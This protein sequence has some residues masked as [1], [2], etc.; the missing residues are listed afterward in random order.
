MALAF[1]KTYNFYHWT[2]SYEG[3]QENHARETLYNLK[4][5]FVSAG[6]IVE[7]SHDGGGTNLGNNDQVDHW[8]STSVFSRPGGND[9]WIV[10]KAPALFG[11]LQICIVCNYSSGTSWLHRWDVFVSPSAGFGSANGG[12]DGTATA[13]PTAT[14]QTSD[15]SDDYY[16]VPAHTEWHIAA[17]TDDSQFIILNR[18]GAVTQT[19]MVFSNVNNPPAELDNGIAYYCYTGANSNPTADADAGNLG[20]GSEHY[21]TARW[22]G[23]ISGTN[24]AM[25]LGSRGYNNGSMHANQIVQDDAKIT[26]YP[27]DLMCNVTTIQGYYGTIPDLY[28]G[29][30]N[31]HNIGLGDALGGPINWYSLGSLIVPWDNS[32]PLPRV[33]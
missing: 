5:L 12:S 14:D 8:T 33:R 18:T 4:E 6:W 26:L 28:Y 11:A 23:S 27:C 16:A 29:A 1:E 15:I 21:T 19:L 31:Q 7:S 2:K 32:Q 20:D 30:N 24:R 25:Y 3:S 22:R 17:A 13:A 9:P 10:L